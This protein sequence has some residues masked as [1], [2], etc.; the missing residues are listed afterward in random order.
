MPGSD[1]ENLWTPW[2]PLEKQLN[3]LLMDWPSNSRMYESYI[4]GKI[5]V[6]LLEKNAHVKLI[7]SFYSKHIQFKH[8][9]TYAL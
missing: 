4:K 7:I 9:Q 6:V 2:F 5:Y 3:N 8:E 1:L